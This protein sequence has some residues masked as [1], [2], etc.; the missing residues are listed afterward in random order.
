MELSFA[1]LVSQHR[2]QP[3]PQPLSMNLS[4]MPQ[5]QKVFCIAS[6]AR[7]IYR[8]A[9]MTGVKPALISILCFC[10]L[11]ATNTPCAAD[12]VEFKVNG[13]RVGRN[14][15]DAAL[16][17]NESI[18]LIRNN[19]IERAVSKLKRAILLAPEL[20][21]PH[22]NLAVLLAQQGRLAEAKSHLLKAV[23][24]ADAPDTAFLNLATLYQ[25]TGDIEKAI[26]NYQIYTKRTGD[27]SAEAALDLLRREQEHQQGGLQKRIRSDYLDQCDF[28]GWVRWWD[29]RMPLKVYIE[30]VTGDEAPNGYKDS[31][32][33]LLR[34]SFYDWSK[35]SSN[36]VRFVFTPQESAADIKCHWTNDPRY[37]GGGAE[38]GETRFKCLAH[39]MVSAD[40]YLRTKE[41]EGAFP[42][43]DNAVKGT[44]LHEIGHSLGISG[45]SL[46]VSDIMFFST[47]FVE[48]DRHI[49]NRDK[50]TLLRLYNLPMDLWSSVLDFFINPETYTKWGIIGLGIATLILPSA[51]WISSLRK[52]K[53]KGKNRKKV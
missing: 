22:T 1:G 20:P 47:P 23:S 40:I 35:I 21:E 15:Y 41:E 5:A 12:E 14:V 10:I 51:L 44:C 43:T 6:L 2:I 38:A 34:Q 26:A 19:C 25:T 30:P 13:K 42:Y 36:K 24:S 37:L 29:S 46:N 4:K 53:R 16:L 50:N 52:R 32:V 39:A 31:Y 3:V 7:C 48:S 33:N 49:S 9:G 17:L 8:Y 28:H 11:F 18:K 45:H 27:K